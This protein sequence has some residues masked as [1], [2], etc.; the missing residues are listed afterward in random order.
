MMPLS[1]EIYIVAIAAAVIICALALYLLSCSQTSRHRE[2]C[3]TCGEQALRSVN[4]VLATVVINGRRAPDAWTYY[5]YE[6][7]QS[8]WKKHIGCDL[9]VPT[10]SE[11]DRHCAHVSR[12]SVG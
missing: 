12:S 5:W 8:R 9:E 1:M 3:P 11:W 6:S 2:N 4:S 10:D 7:C